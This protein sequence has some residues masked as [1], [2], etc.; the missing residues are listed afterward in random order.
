[1]F[2]QRHSEKWTPS[3]NVCLEESDPQLTL[4]SSLT[5]QLFT[6]VLYAQVVS[7]N[8]RSSLSTKQARLRVYGRTTQISNPQETLALHKTPLRLLK[9]VQESN[10]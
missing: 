9:R 7:L 5:T 8:G 10:N 1:M 3:V 2:R 4:K 6:A